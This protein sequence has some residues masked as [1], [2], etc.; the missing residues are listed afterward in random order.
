MIV[1][2]DYLRRPWAEVD[3]SD[4]TTKQVTDSGWDAEGRWFV[5]FAVNLTAAEVE[6][7]QRRLG[8]ASTAEETLQERAWTATQNLLA[9]ESLASPTNAQTLAVVRL[10][11]RAVRA[12]IRLQLRR[13]DS[14]D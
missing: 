5:Q 10:L 2:V 4:L 11:C 14:A 7:V 12:L 8:T 6:A 13:L 9:F 1:T 3:L